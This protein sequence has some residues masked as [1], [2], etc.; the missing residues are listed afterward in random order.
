[1]VTSD[2]CAISQSN[3]ILGKDDIASPCHF[4]QGASHTVRWDSRRCSSYVANGRCAPLIVA[5]ADSGVEEVAQGV[6]EHGDGEDDDGDGRRG[7]A[8]FTSPNHPACE[9]GGGP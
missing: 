2:S 4:C 3:A 9:A 6:A 1:M 5:A 7:E 8:R